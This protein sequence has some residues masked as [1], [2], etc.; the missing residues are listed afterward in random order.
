MVAESLQRLT[1][2]EVTTHGAVLLGYAVTDDTFAR[3]VDS[4]RADVL[5]AIQACVEGVTAFSLRAQTAPA[6]HAVRN[7]TRL[8]QADAQQQRLDQLSA[9]DPL[10]EAAVRVLDLELLN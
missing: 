10:L 4:S 8:T 5:A 3:A 7:I 1:P 9:R 6:A 2:L